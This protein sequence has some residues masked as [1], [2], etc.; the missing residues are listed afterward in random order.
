MLFY[1]IRDN[2][3]GCGPHKSGGYNRLTLRDDDQNGNVY[4]GD[5]ISSTI[6]HPEIESDL[7]IGHSYLFQGNQA[8]HNQDMENGTS[9]CLASLKIKDDDH[10]EEKATRN[11]I[12][13][14]T[15]FPSP[16]SF[17]M[18]QI[19]S[20]STTATSVST[21]TATSP[22][23]PEDIEITSFITSDYN[24]DLTSYSTCTS[25]PDID[26]SDADDEDLTC[27]VCDRSYPTM[28][29][30]VSHQMRRR[31]Y[32][33]SICEDI[34]P[35]YMALEYHK[36][37]YSHLS[38]DEDYY[39]EEEEEEEEEEDEEEEDEE[40]RGEYEE[41]EDFSEDEEEDDKLI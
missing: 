31:H 10:N 9:H 32:G 6:G 37:I 13:R 30:L 19:H 38:E 39:D 7:P 15:T 1:N 35:T 12:L 23:S 4:S 14:S 25:E 28:Q 21:P 2:L 17:K 36:R 5:V 34:F 29:Q 33:C 22:V 40:E 18:D 11:L 27:N 24:D 26:D 20:S 16:T 3:P 8:N 41:G